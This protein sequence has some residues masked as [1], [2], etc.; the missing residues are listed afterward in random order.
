MRGG[1]L[2][3]RRMSDE[4]AKAHYIGEKGRVYHEE[5][6][7]IPDSAF[8]WMA[9]LRAEKF[10]P[11]IRETDSVLEYGVGF[12]WN[13]A[14]IKCKARFGFDVSEF[15]APKIRALGI[16]FVSDI[17]SIAGDS[18]NVVICHHTLEHII[19]PSEALREIHRLLCPG[20]RLLLYVPFEQE[21][22]YRRFDPAEPNHHLYSWNVQ[23]L[24][25]LV[26]DCSF[27]V[28]EAKLGEFGYDRFAAV[29]ADKFHLGESGFHIL[30]KSLHLVKPGRE[31]R[32]VAIK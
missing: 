20:G 7:G 11:H 17:K 5:K 16:E 19:N 28:E 9:R 18:I 6:R 30:R 27:K 10:Q 12:G 32:L 15:L 8:P 1:V 25:N 22:R 3:C 2:R 13:L 31:V 24:G 29:S 26:S 23:T 21:R 14:T 4:N